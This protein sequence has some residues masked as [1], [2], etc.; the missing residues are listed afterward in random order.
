[1]NNLRVLSWYSSFTC[2]EATKEGEPFKSDSKGR[3]CHSRG[4]AVCG[5][6]LMSTLLARS[7][8]VLWYNMSS[9][10]LKKWTRL[11]ETILQYCS[12]KGAWMTRGENLSVWWRNNDC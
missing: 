7:L 3:V 11:Y 10:F 12:E 1:M 9:L 4:L 6:S 5:I 8:T 2:E